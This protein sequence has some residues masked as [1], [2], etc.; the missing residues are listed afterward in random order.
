MMFSLVIAATCAAPVPVEVATELWQVAPD[1]GGKPWAAPDAPSEKS[2]AVVLI[3]G[4]FVHPIRQEKASRPWKRD[5]QEPKSELVKTLARDFDVFAFAYA[6]TVALDEVATSAG[7]RDAIARLRKAGYKEIVLVGH[8]A[9]GVIA[10][11]FVENYPDAGATKVLAVAAPFAGVELANVK[12]G[13]PKAQAPFIQSL[14]PSARADVAK[15]SK[16]PLSKDVPFAC[17]V[18]KPL[19]IVETDFL[20]STHSQW[21]DDLQQCGVRAVH[22]SANHFTVMKD[23][24]AAKTIAEL[25][26]EKLAR[27]SPEETEKV[28]KALFSEGVPP[29]EK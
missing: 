22:S 6:Q 28:R 7:M 13:Y 4:L 12:V 21:P 25:A 10:R 18:C 24:A 14:S 26:R 11:Q 29:R 2:R 27:W 9:G 16:N 17:V 19:K 3:H 20:V 23:A 8:S 1:A 5:W 15:A